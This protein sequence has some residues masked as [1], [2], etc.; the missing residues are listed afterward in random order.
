MN[1][2]LPSHVYLIIYLLH[3]ECEEKKSENI[4]T[5][6]LKVFEYQAGSV[7]GSFERRENSQRNHEISCTHLTNFLRYNLYQSIQLINENLV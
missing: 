1:N 2:C 7:T 5:I 6:I 3:S 4:K